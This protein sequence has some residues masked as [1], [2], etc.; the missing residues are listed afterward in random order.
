MGS[1]KRGNVSNNHTFLYTH[2]K[3]PHVLL[4]TLRG[5][6]LLQNTDLHCDIIHEYIPI[7]LHS[8]KKASTSSRNVVYK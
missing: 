2:G 7:N 4:V 1:Q 8:T 3:Q 5:M 6:F